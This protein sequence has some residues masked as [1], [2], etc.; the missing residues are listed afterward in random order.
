VYDALGNKIATMLQPINQTLGEHT[1]RFNTN[2]LATG[3]YYA[4]IVTE[5][6]VRQ[7]Q[8]SIIH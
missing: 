5:S 1:L 4:V 6:G 2:H 8:F 7:Q 3:Q